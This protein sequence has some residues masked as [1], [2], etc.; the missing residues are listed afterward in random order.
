MAERLLTIK[1]AAS[2]CGCT[3]RHLYK[4]KSTGQFPEFVRLGRSVR[5]LESALDAYLQNGCRLSDRVR[6]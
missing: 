2:A 3:I 1:E 4:L 5:V 6:P